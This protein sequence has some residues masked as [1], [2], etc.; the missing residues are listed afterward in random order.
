MGKRAADTSAA[1]SPHKQ[2][3]GPVPPSATQPA[4]LHP[5]IVR[6]ADA[7]GT[8]AAKAFMSS[9]KP[10]KS[11]AGL[12]CLDAAAY[13]TAMKQCKEYT[14]IIAANDMDIFK[15]A[16]STILPAWGTLKSR[17]ERLCMCSSP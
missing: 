17:A 3:K 5:T 13:K 1:A 15:T 8:P 2:A 11:R 14:C 12:E 7:L 9:L 6:L 4:A 10:A 16:H